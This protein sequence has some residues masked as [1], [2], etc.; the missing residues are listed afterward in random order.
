[1]KFFKIINTEN[2]WGHVATLSAY[3]IF[4]LNVVVCKDLANSH[5]FSPMALFAFRALGASALFWLVSLFMPKEKVDKKDYIKIFAASMLGLFLTQTSFL[6]AITM[7]TPLDTSVLVT[8]SPIFTMF[9]AAIVLKEPITWKKAGG[10]TISFMGVLLLI[11]TGVSAVNGVEQTSPLGYVLILLNV[12][13]FSLYLGIFRP[14][15]SKYHV[16]TFMKWMFLFSMIVTLPFK[17]KEMLYVDYSSISSSVYWELG[18]LIF[19]STFVAYFLIPIGQK[20]LRP[21]MVSMYSYSQPIIASVI[22][23]YMGMDTL[24]WQKIL[25][26]ATVVSGVLLVN[27]SRAKS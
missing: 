14:L 11:F 16:V 21:T 5:T 6:F 27:K 9:I 10:V 13:S 15:I 25:A 20:C 24:S 18:F 23:I 3:L 2:P 19:F 26:A 17:A 7:A 8:L 12:S 1:M 4:G 22:S